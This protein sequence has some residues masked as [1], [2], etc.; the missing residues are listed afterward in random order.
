MKSEVLQ[1]LLD[2]MDRDPWWVKLRRWW[3]VKLWIYKCMTRKYWDSSYHK[4]IFKK[5]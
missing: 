5:N 1:N 2:E 4:Y 3:I